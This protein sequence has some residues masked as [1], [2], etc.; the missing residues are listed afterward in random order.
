[1]HLLGLGLESYLVNYK[2]YVLWLLWESGATFENNF[3]PP[4]NY[5]AIHYSAPFKYK[6][7]VA[8][9][10]TLMDH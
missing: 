9:K 1:M 10:N 7:Q 5:T 4:S 8:K 3:K 2:T 6:H